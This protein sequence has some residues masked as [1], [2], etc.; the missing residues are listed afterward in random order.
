MGRRMMRT[1]GAGLME[2]GKQGHIYRKE[3]LEERRQEIAVV[4]R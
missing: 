4:A 3:Q 1:L 2:A